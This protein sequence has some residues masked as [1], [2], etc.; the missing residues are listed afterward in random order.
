[1][2]TYLS[3]FLKFVFSIFSQRKNQVEKRTNTASSQNTLQQELS[4]GNNSQTTT[5]D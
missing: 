4:F 3:S 1:M 5:T 2:I